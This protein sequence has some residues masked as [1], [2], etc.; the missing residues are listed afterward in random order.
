MSFLS[1]LGLNQALRGFEND[2]LVVNED[3]ERQ[4]VP[5]AIGELMK[6]LMVSQHS[7]WIVGGVMTL[8]KSGFGAITKHRSQR[9]AVGREK[10]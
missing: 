1:S 5:K 8:F 10:T 7:R 2:M 3:W 6:D 9:E 4:K